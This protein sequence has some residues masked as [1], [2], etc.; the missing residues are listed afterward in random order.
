[1]K[2]PQ[3]HASGLICAL[4]IS[5]FGI[6]SE[7]VKPSQRCTATAIF[8]GRSTCVIADSSG[9]VY[10][11]RIRANKWL[12]VGRGTAAGTSIVVNPSRESEIVS[13]FKDGGVVCFD[14]SSGRRICTL[15]DHKDA[16][17]FLSFDNTGSLLVT[18]DSSCAHLWD[19]KTWTRL[20]TLRQPGHVI[21][22]LKFSVS[23]SF[24]L[25][26]FQSTSTSHYII[27][28][29]DPHD[30]HIVFKARVPP[31]FTDGVDIDT[32]ACSNDDSALVCG[33][34]SRP[35][36]LFWD[37]HKLHQGHAT[38]PRFIKLPSIAGVFQLEFLPDNH[39][40]ACGRQDGA[41]SLCNVNAVTCEAAEV[42]R[43]SSGLSDSITG[44]PYYSYC[45]NRTGSLLVGC[46]RD[47]TIQLIDLA[48]S[49][50]TFIHHKALGMQHSE[51][52]GNDDG[53]ADDNDNARLLAP[54]SLTSDQEIR[55]APFL[56]QSSWVDS[57]FKR[58]NA[59]KSRRSTKKQEPVEQE[60]F[61]DQLGDDGEGQQF[62]GSQSLPQLARDI[63]PG[64]EALNR[65]RLVDLYN[66]KGRFPS[67]YRTLIWRFLLK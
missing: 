40:L 47:G 51:S 5:R 21:R 35:G 52:R 66:L 19:A 24:I 29:W 2:K 31:L 50:A 48:V 18:S 6:T 63:A 4:Q 62:S 53:S 12:H 60:D 46:T 61:F 11:L 57:I 28:A 32:F 15:A 37:V 41:I 49:R 56:R 30:H 17:Q 20:H 1:M 16:V 25:A 22:T 65:Q 45:V 58:R 3:V 13:A 36:I 9:N 26:L 23:G 8:H 44:P 10:E 27:V 43:I 55:V 7:H 34:Q 64:H 38:A 39:T 14:S 67:K 42:A 59:R 33:S 54:R